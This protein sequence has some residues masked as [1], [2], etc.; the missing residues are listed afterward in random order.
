MPYNVKF[1]FS[2]PLSTRVVDIFYASPA[3]NPVLYYP[4]PTSSEGESVML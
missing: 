3:I 2:R 1:D 4:V